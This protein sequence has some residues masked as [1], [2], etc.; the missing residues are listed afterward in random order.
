MDQSLLHKLSHLDLH[1]L[2]L[3]LYNSLLQKFLG[4]KKI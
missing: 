4:K 3:S 1:K 2:S